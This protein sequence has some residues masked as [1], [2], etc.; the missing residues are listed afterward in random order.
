MSPP[1]GD[2][3]KPRD[4]RD[5]DD[6]GRRAIPLGYVREPPDL[7]PPMTRWQV[8]A[9]AVFILSVPFL[10]VFLWWLAAAR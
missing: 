3:P 2:V 4:P 10:L 6:G 5:G 9:V 8:V 7:C 1:A